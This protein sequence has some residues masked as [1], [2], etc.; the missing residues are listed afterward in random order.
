MADSIWAAVIGVFGGGAVGWTGA[1]ASLRRLRPDID[2]V[3]ADTA[4]SL[5][6]TALGMLAPYR[7]QV[8]ELR[9]E[10]DHLHLRLDD[11]ERQL[12]A[13]LMENRTLREHVANLEIRL[14]GSQR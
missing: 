10:I 12:A 6:A 5:S 2:R 9:S 4:S 11:S 14:Y 1:Y 8:A 13:M 7:E 3:E